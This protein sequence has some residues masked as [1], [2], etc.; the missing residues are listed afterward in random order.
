MGPVDILVPWFHG[1]SVVVLYLLVAILRTVGSLARQPIRLLLFT[2]A[3][4]K[5]EI[6]LPLSLRKIETHGYIGRK[7]R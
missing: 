6:S 7:P 4:L 3:V 1:L 5:I 2:T